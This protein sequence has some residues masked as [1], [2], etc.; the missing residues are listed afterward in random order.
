M[1]KVKSSVE[2]RPPGRGQ[3]V[4]YQPDP[5]AWAVR[6]NPNGRNG[7]RPPAAKRTPTSAAYRGPAGDSTNGGLGYVVVPSSKLKW[8]SRTA[9]SLPNAKREGNPEN[10]PGFL[11]PP[12]VLLTKKGTPRKRQP[13]PPKAEH[14]QPGTGPSLVNPYTGTPADQLSWSVPLARA[15]ASQPKIGKREPTVKVTPTRPALVKA[16]R[17]PKQKF[18]PAPGSKLDPKT[19]KVE[20]QP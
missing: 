6:R 7:K 4:K 5:S 14:F 18:I 8:A 20:R 15:A 1:A 3:K 19:R 12:I 2:P 16:A 9:R 10:L 13:A 11:S 17:K